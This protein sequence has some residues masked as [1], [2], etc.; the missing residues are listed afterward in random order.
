MDILFLSELES[1][2]PGIS[3][4]VGSYLC[5][6]SSYCLTLKNHISG[7]ELDV[8]G[9]HPSFFEVVWDNEIDEQ[10][11][12]TWNDIQ[13]LT[14]YG[15]TGIAVLLTNKLT[16]FTVI[17]RAPKN[18][19]G[20]DYYLGHKNLDSFEKAARLEISGI[21]EETKS[22]NISGRIRLKIKQVSR[23]RNDLPVYV[24]VIEFGKPTS[25][26]VKI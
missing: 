2:M 25:E 7:V 15:A 18:G 26:I 10:T 24:V 13:E 12:R 19:G 20:V 1:G 9:H 14:E 22:N 16:E 8:K 23:F 21:L 4:R 5:E 17:E 3:P 11:R 6:A